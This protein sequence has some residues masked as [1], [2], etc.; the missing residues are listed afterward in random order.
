M[1]SQIT[2]LV[3]VRNQ[4][5]FPK[6]RDGTIAQTVTLITNICRIVQFQL[7]IIIQ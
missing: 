1:N 5:L 4:N 2:F 7:K 3:K 6:Y